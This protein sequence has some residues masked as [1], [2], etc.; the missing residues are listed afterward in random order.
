[1][2]N[3]ENLKHYVKIQRTM[4]H[5]ECVCI[6]NVFTVMQQCH[7]SMKAYGE[8]RTVDVRH[9][10]GIQFFL[11]GTCLIEA[12]LAISH[13]YTSNFVAAKI[14]CNFPETAPISVLRRSSILVSCGRH[15]L[16]N[17]GTFGQLKAVL[18]HTSMSLKES[19][20]SC[21]R[22]DEYEDMARS[23]LEGLWT[24]ILLN[25][26][27]LMVVI[28]IPWPRVTKRVKWKEPFMAV[29][30]WV[31]SILVGISTF[32]AAEFWAVELMST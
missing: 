18:V 16:M 11:V 1:M 19:W 6:S 22:P 32:C 12:F 8:T 29:I 15:L 23:C 17:C 20:F 9:H 13:P 14:V 27:K 3:S 31:S 2:A 25:Q 24:Y 30:W 5:V 10:V 7:L 26:Q 28:Y 4:L 21:R